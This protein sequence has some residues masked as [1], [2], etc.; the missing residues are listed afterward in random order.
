[1]LHRQGETIQLMVQMYHVLQ[2][3]IICENW[4][5]RP[6]TSDS[7]GSNRAQIVHYIETKYLSVLQIVYSESE[8]S[9]SFYFQNCCEIPFI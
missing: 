2:R 5:S 6:C 8:V 9:V 4:C 3:N 1:M 7:F